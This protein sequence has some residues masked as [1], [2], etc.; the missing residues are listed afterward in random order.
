M[1]AE[2]RQTGLAEE[3]MSSSRRRLEEETQNQGTGLAGD[4]DLKS[5]SARMVMHYKEG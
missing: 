4:I 1:E 2:W 3:E 5:I